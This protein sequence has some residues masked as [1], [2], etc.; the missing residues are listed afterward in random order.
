MSSKRI[1]DQSKVT[2][3]EG[4]AMTLA[5]QMLLVGLIAGLAS[6]MFGVDALARSWYQSWS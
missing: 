3:I 2:R 1:F 4:G 5:G 6:G